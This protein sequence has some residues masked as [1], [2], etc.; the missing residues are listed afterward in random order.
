MKVKR[1]VEHSAA[2]LTCIKI[3]YGFQA[4]VLSIFEWPRKTGFTVLG[5][6]AN[7]ADLD[8]VTGPI[9]NHLYFI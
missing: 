7:I 4:F 2:L 8:P 1:I 9:Q 5:S 3:P 6:L